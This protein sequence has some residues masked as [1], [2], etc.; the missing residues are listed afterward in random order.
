MSKSNAKL[1]LNTGVWLANQVIE[2]AFHFHKGTSV[3]FVPRVRYG[4]FLNRLMV[5]I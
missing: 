5:I 4:A 1:D 3:S 2:D